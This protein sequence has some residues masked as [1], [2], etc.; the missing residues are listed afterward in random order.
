M[1]EPCPSQPRR[2]DT[3]TAVAPEVTAE[4]LVRP[5][6]LTRGRTKS[7]LPVEAIVVATGQAPR[8]PMV[9]QYV[10]ALAACRRPAA[11]AEVA[12]LTRMPLGVTRVLLD[13]LVR[14]GLVMV[15]P[16]SA[17]MADLALV[18]RLIA[19]IERMT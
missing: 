11:V 4:R 18:D 9:R 2:A 1:H 10:E 19:G 6:F 12:S 14:A 16:R 3:E 15:G 13:D 7:A 17:V 5:F 8:R